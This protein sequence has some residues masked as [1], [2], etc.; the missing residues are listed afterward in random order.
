MSCKNAKCAFHVAWYVFKFLFTNKKTDGNQ[1]AVVP[2]WRLR[3]QD[4]ELQDLEKNVLNAADCDDCDDCADCASVDYKTFF[5]DG[6]DEK[7]KHY[8]TT[9]VSV[10]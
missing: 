7:A 2:S 5:R 1:F 9:N 3:R 10:S 8:I 4:E 6:C